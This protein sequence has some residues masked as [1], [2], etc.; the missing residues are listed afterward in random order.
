DAERLG[1]PFER[2]DELLRVEA[3]A[4]LGGRSSRGRV[5]MGQQAQRLEPRELTAQGGRGE[6]ERRAL[7]ERA[8]AD[9]LAGRD[10]LLDDET[11][12]LA[13]CSRE[14]HRSDC[15]RVAR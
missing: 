8:R 4:A 12:D 2:V 15:S 9:R 3:V 5:R 10:V 14:L 7:D 13:I 6:A 11:Q 1:A